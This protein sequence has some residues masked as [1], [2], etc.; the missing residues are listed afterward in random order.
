MLSGKYIAFLGKWL[1]GFRMRNNFGHLGR[2]WPGYLQLPTQKPRIKIPK[3]ARP[4]NETN[5]KNNT[6]KKR[7]GDSHPPSSAGAIHQSEVGGI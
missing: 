2:G 6:I 5:K 3:F 7:H 1:A 4:R